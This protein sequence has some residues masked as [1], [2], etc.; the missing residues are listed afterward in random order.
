[1]PNP[2]ARDGDLVGT[3]A[4][5]MPSPIPGAAIIATAM[6]VFINGKKV[7]RIGDAIEPHGSGEHA[8][9]VLTQ[10]SETVVAEG[11]AICRFGDMASCGHVVVTASPNVKAG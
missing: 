1:M 6:Q 4:D 7:A 11:K 2:V 5:G 3:I 9:A 8:H 10:G